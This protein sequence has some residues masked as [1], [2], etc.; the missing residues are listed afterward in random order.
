M[1]DFGNEDV[2]IGIRQRNTQQMAVCAAMKHSIVVLTAVLRLTDDHPQNT[3][4]RHSSKL[5]SLLV[6]AGFRVS[7][8]LTMWC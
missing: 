4:S 3:T 2:F 8:F 7:L 6:F 5:E 1:R